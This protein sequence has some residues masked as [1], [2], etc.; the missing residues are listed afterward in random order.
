M[1]ERIDHLV[2][3][4]RSLKATLGFDERVLGFTREAAPGRPAAL[5]FGRQKIDLHEVDSRPSAAC[6]SG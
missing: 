5:K 1:I 6:R 2:L 3:T 4:V